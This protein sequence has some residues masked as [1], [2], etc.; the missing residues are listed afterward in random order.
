MNHCRCQSPPV[1][2]PPV[3]A[4]GGDLWKLFSGPEFVAAVLNLC[5]LRL[6]R[7]L[8]SGPAYL[9]EA[10]RRQYRA[11][12][13]TSLVRQ[14]SCNEGVGG[15]WAA[16]V[17]VEGGLDAPQKLRTEVPTSTERRWGVD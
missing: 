15:G 14:K 11:A 10:W 4:N 6:R 8:E 2:C 5:A 9:R 13:L 17:K 16:A 3:W 12:N 7:R 1:W